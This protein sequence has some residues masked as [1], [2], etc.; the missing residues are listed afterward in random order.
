MAINT[1]LQF[2][3][4]VDGLADDTF[5]VLEFSGMETLSSPFHFHIKLASRLE[6][7]V[8]TQTVDRFG[9][10]RIWNNGKLV[11]VRHG[12]ISEFRQ[13]DTGH[14]HTMYE[15][16]LVPSIARLALRQNTRMFQQQ[17]A[18]EIIQLILQEM[19]IQELAFGLTKEPKVRDYCVQYRESD[20][21]F[22]QRLAAEEGMYYYF[23][24]SES[25]HI[26]IFSDDTKQA[27]MLPNELEYNA[28]PGGMGLSAFIRSFTQQAKICSSSAELKDYSFLNP[29]NL[30]LHNDFGSELDFQRSTYEHYDYPGR[31]KED[32]IGQ[33]FAK[34]RLESLRSEALTAK[35]L[36]NY[37]EL[38]SGFKFS[39]KEHPSDSCNRAWFT[40]AV[41]HSGTQPQALEEAGT[42]GSTTYNN[43][44]VVIPDHRQWKPTP[45]P[46]PRVDGP[47]IATVV[48]PEGE[49]IFCDKHGRVKVYFPWDRYNTKYNE[50]CSCWIRVS[51]GWAGGQYGM[52][53]IP[54]IG[55][56][57]IV[58]FLEGDPDQP[59]ITGRTYHATNVPP[60]PL[61]ENKTRTVLRTET[62]Q[63]DGYNEVRFEDQA[64]KEEIYIHAQKDVNMLVEND[65]SDHVKNNL[66]LDVDK[67]RFSRIKV[68]DHQTVEGESRH[69]IK[70]DQ[71][72]ITD[73]SL[74]M[75]QGK[76]M[77]VGAGNEIHLKAGLKIVIEAGSEITL[78]AGGSFVKIDGS[79]VT[80]VGAAINLNSGGSAGSG[81]GYG[82]KLAV[83]PGMVESAIELDEAE[84]PEA[85][86]LKKTAPI[87]E[88]KLAKSMNALPRQCSKES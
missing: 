75:K 48:G 26:I 19:G 1:G 57:V 3:F 62:H 74:H 6:D 73:S 68:N 2:T 13:G 42:S 15:V 77:L 71:T 88:L 83:L 30:L 11:Q 35:G 37:P 65:R 53:A 33:K 69:Y 49:E 41:S 5:S 43:E 59:I 18:Q 58:S 85:F 80:V 66:H 39:Q 63:G 40:I 10:L 7:I 56:E 32:A 12:I 17:P 31:Y 14:H 67:E 21:E 34:F 51:Q 86:E 82:G 22:V 78:K 45:N 84:L 52:M 76:A 25:S 81:S 8:P 79:G 36:S 50:T 9:I 28:Q 70:G 47:Q 29:K 24:H 60:Y 16:A 27:P 64:D 72:V 54:R 44:F 38:T 61:P 46:K 4:Q 55:H 23:E 20:L 87:K